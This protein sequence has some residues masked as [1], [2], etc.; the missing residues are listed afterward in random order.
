VAYD[1]DVGHGQAEDLRQGSLDAE[2]ALGGVPD[3]EAV[4]VPPGDG[5]VRLHG[6]VDL[7][8]GPVGPFH[9][10]ISLGKAGG[11]VAA[12]ANSRLTDYVAA[13]LHSRCIRLESLGVVDDEG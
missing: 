6:G 3:R 10:H 11:E 7:A 13:L 2:N 9:H 1:P 8:L 12:F 4:A 5:S